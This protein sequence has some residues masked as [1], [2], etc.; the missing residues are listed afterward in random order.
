M[1]LLTLD[2][3]CLVKSFFSYHRTIISTAAARPLYILSV[4][5]S[6]YLVN[7]ELVSAGVAQAV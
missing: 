2:T 1:V 4:L 3:D 6:T 5:R 7:T